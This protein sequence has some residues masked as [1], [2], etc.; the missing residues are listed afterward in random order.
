MSLLVDEHNQH[1]PCGV[2]QNSISL[3]HLAQWL[4]KG[5]TVS[6]RERTDSELHFLQLK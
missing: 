6:L 3:T 5:V 1:F 2:A 4:T